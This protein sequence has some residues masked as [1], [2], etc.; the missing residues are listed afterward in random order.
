MHAL[1]SI[2]NQNS[3]S[4]IYEKFCSYLSVSIFTKQHSF[5]N[6]KEEKSVTYNW[7]IHVTLHDF[8]STTF[9]N[10]SNCTRCALLRDMENLFR[11]LYT[12]VSQKH[13][14]W[15]LVKRVAK[16]EWGITMTYIYLAFTLNQKMQRKGAKEKLIC[17]MQTFL[18]YIF[19]LLPFLPAPNN[20]E[21]WTSFLG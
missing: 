2:W 10:K 12:S 14:Y 20:C 3:Y 13:R 5:C 7:I 9:F 6:L 18:I 19:I 17:S 16:C 21:K 11:V 15:E 1:L 8:Y 4:V